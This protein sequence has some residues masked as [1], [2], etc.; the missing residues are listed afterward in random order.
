MDLS[1]KLPV[2]G[3]ARPLDYHGS[4]EPMMLNLTKKGKVLAY[5]KEIEPEAFLS[6]EAQ[7]LKSRMGDKNAEIEV[8]LIIRAD[9]AVEFTTL[10]RLIQQCQAQGFRRFSL[11]AVSHEGST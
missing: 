11:S 5:G 10:N 8:P 4:T 6:R 2:L 7:F 9:R 3:S 1:L